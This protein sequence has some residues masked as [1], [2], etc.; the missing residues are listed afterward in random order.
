MRS[1]SLGANGVQDEDFAPVD[2]ARY[3]LNPD[4]REGLDEM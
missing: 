4:D 2:G 3:E 1:L